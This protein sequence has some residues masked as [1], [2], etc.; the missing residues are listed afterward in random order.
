[1]FGV[2]MKTER[3]EKILKEIQDLERRLYLVEWKASALQKTKSS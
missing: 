3:Q 1:M 2:Y